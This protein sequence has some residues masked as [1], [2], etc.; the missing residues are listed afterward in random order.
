MNT[1]TQRLLRVRTERMLAGVAGGLARYFGI[2]PIIVRLIFV[3]LGLVNGIGV[4]IYLVLWLLMPNE[5][6]APT[7]N[8]LNVAIGEMQDVVERLFAEIRDV[9]RRL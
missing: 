7:D 3:G 6:A 4:I 2:D 1:Q 8:N 9:L 5:D